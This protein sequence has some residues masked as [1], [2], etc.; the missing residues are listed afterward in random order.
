MT[1]ISTNIA[2]AKEL[3]EVDELVAIPT[4]TVYGLAANAFSENAVKK[5]F[6]LK[7]RPAFNPL[8]V[9]ISSV[10]ELDKIAVNIPPLALELAKAFWPG[11]LTL[12]LEKN[13]I[14][15][16]CVTAGNRTVAVRVPNHPDTL[17]L[18]SQL[19]FPLAAPS[20]NPFMSISPT[21]PEHVKD[22]FEGKLKFILDGGWCKQGIE[23]TIIGFRNNQAV[24]YRIGS[25][26]IVDIERITGKLLFPEIAAPSPEAPG[27]LK[28]HYAP[29]TRLIVT[30]NFDEEIQNNQGKKMGILT[31][32]EMDLLPMIFVQKHLSSANSLKEAAANLYAT[33][34]ELDA[35]NLDLIIAEYMPNTG[36]G[37]TINDRL[38]R[39]SSL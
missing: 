17:K 24:L 6:A 8:I 9:H 37:N 29:K 28:K 39:A 2:I 11:P 32:S 20:A 23:S 35:M 27:M 34:I 15:P 22:Y 10:L 4:E 7:K 16:E 31:F 12:L 36:L 25:C 14:I 21:K 38:E 26:E 30:T 3:L 33:L 1:Q 13:D 5:I 18:L 19:S